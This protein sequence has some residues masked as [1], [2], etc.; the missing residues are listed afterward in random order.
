VTRNPFTAIDHVQIAM[1][2]GGEERARAFYVGLLGMMEMAKPAELAGRGGCW[3]AC[4]VVQI[5]LG[6]ERDFRPAKKAH[7]GLRCFDYEGLSARLQAAGVEVQEDDGIPGV[8]RCHIFDPFGNRIEL[9]ADRSTA[10]FAL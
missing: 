2:A 7:P 4:G 6:V 9:I 1:P 8:R 5:H 3:F 10:G